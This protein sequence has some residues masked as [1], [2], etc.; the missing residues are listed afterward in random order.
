MRFAILPVARRERRHGSNDSLR[1][2]GS[3]D[4]VC[5]GNGGGIG[6]VAAANNF[7]RAATSASKTF[8]SVASGTGKRHAGVGAAH[9]AARQDVTAVSERREEETM[10]LLRYPLILAGLV[11]FGST[12]ALV[13]Y[14]VYL[15]AQLRR[16]LYGSRA[17]AAAQIRAEDK[18]DGAGDPTINLVAG[19]ERRGE[20][21]EFVKRGGWPKTVQPAPAKTPAGGTLRG[22]RGRVIH[23]TASTAALSWNVRNVS[24]ASSGYHPKRLQGFTL[25]RQVRGSATRPAQ[26][27][28]RCTSR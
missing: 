28:A 15:S 6:L 20:G 23:T 5:S 8:S 9:G 19:G 1:R 7:R 11:L 21:E 10:L 24:A 26:T 27:T 16:L 13:A 14:D 17:K 25:P 2:I 22:W 18:R 3:R 12:G 4:D